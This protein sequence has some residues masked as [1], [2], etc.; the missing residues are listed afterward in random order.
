MHCL[1]KNFFSEREKSLHCL[2]P[3]YVGF[4]DKFYQ[5]Q[6]ILPNVE[7]ILPNKMLKA[8]KK[9]KINLYL[10]VYFTVISI[11]FCKGPILHFKTECTQLKIDT[12]NYN[13]LNCIFCLDHI[14]STKVRQGRE[15]SKEKIAQER[16]RN[17]SQ[18]TL[19]F[20]LCMQ[21][22]TNQEI[23]PIIYAVTDKRK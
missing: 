18:F 10:I 14:A 17:A 13:C 2:R 16:I 20:M 22:T 11:S 9:K 3:K 8:P 21:N 23:L 5:T 4:S 1:Q 19:S 12:E 7:K 15:L 6:L